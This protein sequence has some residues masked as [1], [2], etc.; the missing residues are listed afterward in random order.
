MFYPESTAAASGAA[1]HAHPHIPRRFAPH[2]RPAGPTP[3]ALPARSA[4]VAG[5]VSRG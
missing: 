1:A 5:G 2:D 3:A 4:A